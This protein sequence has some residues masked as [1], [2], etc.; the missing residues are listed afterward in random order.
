MQGA[1][2]LV[3]RSRKTAIKHSNNVKVHKGEKKK[4]LSS[5]GECVCI[6]SHKSLLEEML[7]KMR[8]EG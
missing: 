1:P 2:I 3:G 4:K 6:S 7:F 5:F 8:T